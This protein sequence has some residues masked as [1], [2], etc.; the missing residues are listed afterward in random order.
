VKTS[1]VVSSLVLLSL[2]LFLGDA[3]VDQ[4]IVL[5]PFRSDTLSYDTGKLFIVSVAREAGDNLTVSS[6]WEVTEQVDLS[7]KSMKEEFPKAFVRLFPPTSTLQV[8]KFTQR[9]FKGFS[10]P[11]S[12]GFAYAD[13]VTINSLWVKPAFV[14]IVKKLQRPEALAVVIS[15]KGWKDTI[16][17]PVYDDPA[18]ENRTLYKAPLQLVP[19]NNEIYFSPA[20]NRNLAAAFAT[21]YEHAS[22][23]P[24]DRAERF[25]NS[26]IEQN[27]ATCHEGLPSADGGTTMT[28]D[29]NVCH[30]EHQLADYIHG[31]VEM[32]EC[33]TCHSWSVEKKAL[34]VE[35]GVPG[36]CVTCHDDKQAAIDSSAYPHPVASE[37]TTCH[38]PHSS[39]RKHLLKDDTNKLCAGCHEGFDINHPVGR[40][41]VRFSINQVTGEEMSCVS[42][43]KPH[44]SEFPKLLISGNSTSEICS[45]CH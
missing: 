8:V 2:F 31:P 26:E 23:A 4:A 35:A 29:C 36:V 14:D 3:A 45:Q 16:L 19:G 42:C 25:H 39:D 32:K 18:A 11:D 13:T 5:L 9:Y 12:F 7:T 43:H 6:Q 1:H 24:A 37:C 15:M 10:V 40:H 21:R 27:C 20:G 41:P 28:A 30:K 22:V 44:G 34:I 33:G 17:T 38:S